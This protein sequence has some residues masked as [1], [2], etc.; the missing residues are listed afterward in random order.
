M[1][2]RQCNDQCTKLSRKATT[3]IFRPGNTFGMGAE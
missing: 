2:P 3:P 1:S